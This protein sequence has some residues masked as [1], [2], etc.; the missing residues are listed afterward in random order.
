MSRTAIVQD[1]FFAPGGSEEVAVA[2]ADLLP[3]SDVLTSFMEPAYRP[4]LTGHR[5]HTWPLQRLV[6]PTK[7]YRHFLPLYPL[8]F[9]GLDLRDRDLVV[10]SSSAFAKSVRTRNGATHIAYIHAPMRYAWDLDGYLAG[11]SLSPMARLAAMSL[12][13]WLRRWDRRTGNRPDVLV[14]NSA[15]VAGRIRQRWGRE[16]RV[17]HPPVPLDDISLSTMDDGYL[18]IA[19]RMLA[20]RRIDVAVAAAT[21]LGRGLMV[22]GSGP[23]EAHLRAKAGP[24]VRFLGTVDRHHLR[25]LMAACHAYLVPGE[26]D[27]GM[28]PVE[29]MAAGKPVIALRAGGALET[30]VDGITGIHVTDPSPAAFISA[31]ERLDATTFDP[32]TIREHALTFAP[33]VFR[34]KFRALFRELGV[35]DSLYR[36]DE[37]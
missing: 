30:V 2:L 11:A 17:I 8:W 1:W 6:G 32:A 25:A 28:A 3:G 26:E 10:S 22:V 23:E 27:F 33:T 9:G 15:A 13:P 24:T 34:S 29:A 7:H 18:L 36:V 16:A 14:A 31:I 19:A 37:G 12:R 20:Y 21:D 4:R 5:I 35:D